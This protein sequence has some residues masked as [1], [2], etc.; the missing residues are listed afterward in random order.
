MNAKYNY[1]I[2]RKYTQEDIDK[3]ITVNGVTYD[4]DRRI[5]LRNPAGLTNIGAEGL[6]MMSALGFYE[7]TLED[8]IV[9]WELTDHLTDELGEMVDD[10]DTP[11][12]IFPW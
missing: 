3:M 6:V 9:M 8:V 10:W 5:V 2:D 12:E 1:S 11:T 4:G 7:D